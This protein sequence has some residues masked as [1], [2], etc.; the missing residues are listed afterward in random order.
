MTELHEEGP[1]ERGVG[2]VARKVNFKYIPPFS[3]TATN[4]HNLIRT[5]SLESLV[6]LAYYPGFSYLFTQFSQSR[7]KVKGAEREDA[8][9]VIPCGGCG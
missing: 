8:G 6:K 3:Q 1:A 7:A 2:H 5:E 9:R 4:R